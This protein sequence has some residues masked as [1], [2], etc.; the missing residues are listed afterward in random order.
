MG[1]FIVGF[2]EPLINSIKQEEDC[3]YFILTKK[4]KYFTPSAILSRT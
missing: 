4:H 2:K 1:I 3:Q